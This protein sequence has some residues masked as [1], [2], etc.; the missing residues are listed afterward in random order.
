MTRLVRPNAPKNVLLLTVDTWRADRMSVYGYERPTTPTLERFAETGQV[1]TNAFTIGPFTQIACVPLFTSSRPLSYGGYDDGARGGR[2]NT[3]FKQ[4]KLA[5]HTT[6]GLSTMHWISSFFG[7]L[8]NFDEAIEIFLL[9]AIPGMGCNML[10][11]PLRLWHEGSVDDTQAIELVTPA[12]LKTFHNIE[13]YCKMMLNN[14]ARLTTLFPDCKAVND[15]YDFRRVLDVVAQHRL[16]FTNRPLAY[17]KTHF[18]CIPQPHE[19]IAKDWR[20]KRDLGKISNQVFDR[21]LRFVT[22]DLARLRANRFGMSPDAHSIADAVINAISMHKKTQPFLIWAHFKDTHQPFVSGSGR[23]WFKQTPD[24]LESLGLDPRIY[25]GQ[26]FMDR[27]KSIEDWKNVNALY[28]CAIRSTDEAIGRI[29]AA[30]NY[31]GLRANTIVGMAGDHGEEIGEH[32]DYGHTVSPYEHTSHIP[33][34]FYDPDRP[35]SRIEGLTTSLDFAPTIAEMAGIAP[36]PNWEG[37]PV[38][39]P[40]INDRDHILM[41]AFCRGTCMFEHRPP[42]LAI[43]TKQ[44]KYLWREFRDPFHIYGDGGNE[45]FDLIRDPEEAHNIYRPDHPV[46]DELNCAL[47]VRLAEIPEISDKRIVDS[48]GEIGKAAIAQVRESRSSP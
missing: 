19:W 48:F 18:Q 20:Y 24:Y 41:E 33:M 40:A 47:A 6:W 29:L 36:D 35:A 17:M 16:D 26:V 31:N 9:N 14:G 43:R 22:P 34:M 27:P 30:I 37:Q 10:R 12:I 21:F 8:E 1:C 7:Y 23:N 39:D 15:G 42:Y 32:G 2:P 46:L 13:S 4:F 25:P 38:T 11:D 28:D 5:G 44:Y 3:L 45:L